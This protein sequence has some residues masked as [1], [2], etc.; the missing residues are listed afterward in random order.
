MKQLN[1]S[2]CT[3]TYNDINQTLCIKED[4]ALGSIVLD[5]DEIQELMLFLVNRDL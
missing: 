2:H 5:S 4:D 1:I 3:F